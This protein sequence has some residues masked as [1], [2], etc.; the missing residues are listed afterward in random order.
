MAVAER[1]RQAR[2]EA[3]LTLEGVAEAVGASANTVWRY[4]AAQR[5]PSGLAIYALAALYRKPVAWFFQ[6][7]GA[8]A[9]G[10]GRVTHAPVTSLEP[11][12]NSPDEDKEF[13]EGFV[14]GLWQYLHKRDMAQAATSAREPDDDRWDPVPL[15]EVAPAAGVGAEVFGEEVV[16]YMPFRRYWLEERSIDPNEAAVVA[17]SGDSMLPTLPDGCA[18]LVDRKRREPQEGRIYVMQTEDGLVVKRLGRDAEGKWEARSD[19]P[20]W[21]PKLLTYGSGIVGEVRWFAV[22]L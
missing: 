10:V 14:R 11:P 16:G 3:G 18:I 2:K 9:D 22:T 12:A 21:G 13:V 17:V 1:L 5:N 8:G 7:V 15:R 6:E 19:N 20:N 4:E